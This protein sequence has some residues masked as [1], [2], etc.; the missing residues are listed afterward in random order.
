MTMM[1]ATTTMMKM[2]TAVVV[3][4]LVAALKGTDLEL[5]A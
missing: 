4:A 1:T 2:M 3:E 5:H